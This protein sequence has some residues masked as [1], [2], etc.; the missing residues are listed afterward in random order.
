MASHSTVVLCVCDVGNLAACVCRRT[1]DKSR[2]PGRTVQFKTRGAC[3][4][5]IRCTSCDQAK[6]LVR[7]RE[8]DCG[9]RVESRVRPGRRATPA[10]GQHVEAEGQDAGAR[11]AHA[12]VL[13][14]RHKEEAVARCDVGAID[15]REAL[16]RPDRIWRDSPEAIAPRLRKNTVELFSSGASLNARGVRGGRIGA[17]IAVVAAVMRW[18]EGGFCGAD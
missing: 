15:Y 6:T 1:Q 8:L 11:W 3:R 2:L 5:I 18:Y 17:I 16:P 7:T 12:D 10:V 9:V 13:A 4:A 14:G